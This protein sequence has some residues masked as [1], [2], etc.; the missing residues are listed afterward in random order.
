[1]K[2]NIPQGLFLPDSREVKQSQAK[3]KKKIYENR[4]LGFGSGLS[5]V[6]LVLIA[7]QVSLYS[8]TQN[9]LEDVFPML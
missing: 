5:Y 3:K 2:I 4:G 8:V 1:M 9:S 7:T 6:N